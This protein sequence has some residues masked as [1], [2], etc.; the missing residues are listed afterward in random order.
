V[1]VPES[2]G[3]HLLN[4]GVQSRVHPER[5]GRHAS[6][7]LQVPVTPG[8][9][10]AVGV[11]R[12]NAFVAMPFHPAYDDVYFVGIRAAVHSVGGEVVRVDQMM[13]GGDAVSETL[14]RISLCDVVIADLSGGETDVLYEVGY[15]HALKKPVVQLCSTPY[16][17]LPFMV[18]NRET[19]PYT[20]GRTH[21]L[22]AELSI[23]LSRLLGLSEDVREE[24]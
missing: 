24:A 15:A 7:V 14:R 17:D 16:D 22:V 8:V 18:R 6:K 23:Y 12:F 9:E 4:L 21:L 11:P 20:P 1:K 10:E 19:V 3:R 5:Y 13:H 2:A